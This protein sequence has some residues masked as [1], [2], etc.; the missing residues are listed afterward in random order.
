MK[1]LQKNKNSVLIFGLGVVGWAIFSEISKEYKET[2]SE[3]LDWQSI[4]ACEKKIKAFCANKIPSDTQRLDIVWS[5]GKTLFS[6]TPEETKKD[7]SF[8]KRFDAVLS[9]AVRNQIPNAKIRYILISS[10]GG[11]F[12]GQ[13]GIT[14]QSEPNPKRPYATLKL[15]QERYI[16]N[17]DWINEFSIVR[18]SSVYSI[19]NLRSRMGL[20]PTMVNKAI[21]QE[22]LSI[23]GTEMTLRD[24]VLDE[25][26]G[27]FIA[28][29]INDPLPQKIFVVD[30]KPYSILEIKNLVEAT[31]QKKVYLNYTLMKS[32]A[33]NNSYSRQVRAKGFEPSYL[34]TNI[35]LLYHNL[36]AGATL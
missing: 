22:F 3:K 6:A 1:L 21:R 4:E 17:A 32:N 19:S 5:A 31:T 29:M 34:A 26:I 11:L 13:T 36:L 30:G 10:A 23:Y 8:F 7:L 28:H 9:E 35:R 2:A 15:N 25:D 33:E 16:E 27:R 18:L 14:K 20:I 12:E 24:Y